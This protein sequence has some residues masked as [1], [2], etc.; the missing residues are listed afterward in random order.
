MLLMMEMFHA[1]TLSTRITGVSLLS[2]YRHVSAS[3]A[4]AAS[5][6]CTGAGQWHTRTQPGR[7]QT[8]LRLAKWPISD[9]SPSRPDDHIYCDECIR[10]TDLLLCCEGLRQCRHGK[11]VL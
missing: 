3:P 7:I 2:V 8:L 9:A 6:G 4:S 10:R 5:L 1:V 11:R